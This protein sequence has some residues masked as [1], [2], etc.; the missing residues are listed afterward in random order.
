MSLRLVLA[1]YSFVL[2]IAAIWLLCAELLSS[3]VAALP[4]NRETALA[5]VRQ[6]SEALWA[7]RFGVLRG[8]L[9]SNA[10]FTYANLGWVDPA[11]VPA[12]VFDEAKA[13]AMRATKLSPVNPAVWLIMADFASRSGGR[14]PNPSESLKMSY[15]TGPN[16]DALIP[17]RLAT[18]ARLDMSADTELE[19]LF[20]REVENALTYRPAL[21]PAIRIAYQ[22]ATTQ[23]RHS[24]EQAAKRLDP[25]FAQG[26][27][28][29]A[30]R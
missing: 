7:A 23:S 1:L 8:E 5:A 18:A 27:S 2:A 9:W 21:K 6:R 12:P 20:T 28:S 4:T 25:A 15:Y 30:G 11:T 24:I 29:A 10:A 14:D 16:E 19:L 3:N 22:Q 17:L 13:M 26:L